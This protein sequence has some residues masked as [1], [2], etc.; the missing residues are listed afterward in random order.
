MVTNLVLGKNPRNFS[1]SPDEQF[2][3]VTNQDTDNI[4]SF[5]RDA[6]T[7]KLTFVN[8]V[9]APMPR[10]YFVLGF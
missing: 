2:L 3:L 7:G 1:L 9:A 10:L 4:V 6:T 8:D 5:K